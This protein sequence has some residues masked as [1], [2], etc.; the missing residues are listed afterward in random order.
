VIVCMCVF[1]TVIACVYVPKEGKRRAAVTGLLCM[2]GTVFHMER[3][4]T[5]GQT[6]MLIYLLVSVCE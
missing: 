6:C 1:V 5:G 4:C 2:C 3:V